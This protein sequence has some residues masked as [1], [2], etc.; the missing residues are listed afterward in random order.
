M[1]R[2]LAPWIL[3][4][5]AACSTVSGRPPQV[6]EYN[7]K[8]SEGLPTGRWLSEKD[9]EAILALAQSQL[10]HIQPDDE[11]RFTVM[12]HADLSLD[13]RVG[14]DGYIHFPVI[15]KVELAGRN[16]EDVRKDIKEKL[17][18]DYLRSAEVTVQVR[19]YAPKRVY[20]LGSVG[21]PGQ[22]EITGGKNATV[23]QAVA[24]ARGFTE[25]A[26]RHNV[27]IY[28]KE[29]GSAD[30]VALC[31]DLI[32]MKGHDP[33][34]L[35]N[36][37]IFV[38]SRERISVYGQVTRPGEFVS[39]AGVTMTA[40]QAIALAGGYTRIANPSNVRLSRRLKDGKRENFVIDLSQVADGKVNEDVPLQPGDV[41]FVPESV[42]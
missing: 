21:A 4:L 7:P 25:D 11:V 29:Q 17:E 28:R 38:P 19:T 40:T 3:V 10:G 23:L 35:P 2:H 22:Y 14:A 20:V 13:T 24:Q 27:V 5:L 41:L 42:F 6:N 37:V 32:G 9:T 26:G 31:V 15:G 8:A 12:G 39:R 18:R 30:R 1:V 16:V 33:V 34:L 36:D